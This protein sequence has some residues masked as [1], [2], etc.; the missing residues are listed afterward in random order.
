MT[1]NSNGNGAATIEY[2]VFVALHAAKAFSINIFL[3]VRLFF[4]LH[5]MLVDMSLAAQSI[6]VA[7]SYHSVKLIS[8]KG[9]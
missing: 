2:L 4:Y 8:E 6:S 3:H 1:T 9:F 5:I 7:L